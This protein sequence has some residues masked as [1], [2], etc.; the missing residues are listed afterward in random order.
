MSLTA[1]NMKMVVYGTVI[2]WLMVKTA[3][4]RLATTKLK[5]VGCMVVRLPRAPPMQCVSWHVLHHMVRFTRLRLL[6]CKNAWVVLTQ[7]RLHE[8]QVQPHD[9]IGYITNWLCTMKSRY[10]LD[11]EVE[12]TQ[13]NR[14]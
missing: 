1:T 13:A 11:T 8:L 2:D 10:R 4:A 3:L 14:H 9:Q 7:F 6:H 12:V 5:C